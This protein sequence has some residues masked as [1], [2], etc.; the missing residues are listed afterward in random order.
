MDAWTRRPPSVRLT[1]FRA[2]ACG[3][4]AVALVL[5]ACA[6]GQAQQEPSSPDP[7]GTEISKTPADVKDQGSYGLGVSIGTQ[8]RGLG[9]TA[10]ALAMERII[11]GLRDALSGKT[12]LSA[13]ENE[14]VVALIEGSR[15]ALG[16]S[17]KD[18]A[19]KFL[20]ENGKRKGVVTTPS[21][22]QYRIVSEGKGAPPKST[23][24]VTVHY[25]GT[26]LDGT[27]FD[28]SMKRGEPA[29]FPVNGV[30]KGWQEALVLM[31][32][33]AKWELFIPPELAYDLNSPPAIPP[34]S[35]LRFDV[36]L[37]SIGPQQGE[38]GPGSAEP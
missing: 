22:L 13:A 3:A 38:Q 18:A 25:R 26:L 30:I 35:L 14:T 37:L 33:G 11:Q 20:A 24:Q 19:R 29:S 34:G 16:N 21:G 10:D 8:L 1:R 5:T 27:E 7:E 31:K 4:A 32:P 17:N 15:S 28:S 9:L 36:E 12:Q 23:D 6:Q 2:L